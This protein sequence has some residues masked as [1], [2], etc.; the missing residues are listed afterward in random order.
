MNRFSNWIFPVFSVQET[1][2]KITIFVTMALMLDLSSLVHLD[3][4][5]N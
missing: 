3:I 2:I 5:L 4:S 1:V